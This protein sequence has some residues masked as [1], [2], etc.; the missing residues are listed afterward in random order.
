MA[1]LKE[2]K[3]EEE[4][5]EEEAPSLGGSLAGSFGGSGPQAAPNPS[6]NSPSGGRFVN[7]A[8]RVSANKGTTDRLVNKVAGQV[9]KAAAGTGLADIQRQFGQ[10][11]QAGA[12]FGST[13]KTMRDVSKTQGTAG[14]Q[15]F[16]A[17]AEFPSIGTVTTTNPA[18][19]VNNSGFG[20]PTDRPVP[21]QV[22]DSGFGLPNEPAI[23]NAYTGPK[24]LTEVEGFGNV[25]ANT[26]RAAE[27]VNALTAPGGRQALLQKIA[28]GG[29]QMDAALLNAAGGGRFRAL[30][31]KYK[32]QGKNLIS[33][34]DASGVAGARVSKQANDAAVA[35][36][37]RLAA[38]RPDPLLADGTVRA[39][40]GVVSPAN[41]GK[42]QSYDEFVAWEPSDIAR[43]TAG[44]LS[45][46]DTLATA[47]GLPAPI[48][49][50]TDYFENGGVLPGPLGGPITEAVKLIMKWLDDAE[51]G[52]PNEKHGAGSGFPKTK[53]VLAMVS[54]AGGDARGLYDSMTPE[55]LAD[56]ESRTPREIFQILL[57]KIKD[58]PPPRRGA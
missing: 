14:T 2:Y 28:G 17:P 30:A 3:P 32:D 46:I 15:Q 56:L 10:D 36:Q 9:E 37:A 34:V 41:N 31:D 18:T 7:F 50:L 39:D 23:P 29:N 24:D 26:G 1:Y 4:Q 16:A 8:N 48:D 20:L 19:M 13:F 33:A 21:T 38:E 5:D 27:Q 42:G 25:V 44:A 12:G 57:Q 52:S 40:G 43:N 58:T 47:L 51:E 22:N 54:A 49:L 53:R 45:P 11:S 55:A 6:V 35:N